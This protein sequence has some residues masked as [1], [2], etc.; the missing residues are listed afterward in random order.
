MR[1]TSVS[2]GST[3]TASP[4]SSAASALPTPAAPPSR[5]NLPGLIALVLA[6]LGFISA[7]VP[8]ASGFSWLFFVPAIVLAIV[9]LVRRGRPRRLALIGLLVSVV[10]WI[11]AIVV[12]VV[13]VLAGVGTGIDG[14]PIPEATVSS[15]GAV[16]LGQAV[17]N[18]AGVQFTLDGVQCGLTSTG[19]DFFDETPAGE[20]CRIDYTVKNG[21][22]EALSLLAGDV[23][24]FVGATTYEADAATGRFGEDYFTTDLNP[25]LSAACIVF[26]DVPVGSALDSVAFAPA[27]SFSE[28]VLSS[29][30]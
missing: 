25:G 1:G 20:F 15:S 19:S 29:V 12:T 23:K 18:S 24:G 9:G 7:V 30:N 6:V 14:L 17:T 22:T 16:P 5:P 4:D 8:L 2:D 21:G 10:G 26:V 13:T 27:L 28:P 3:A 11:V